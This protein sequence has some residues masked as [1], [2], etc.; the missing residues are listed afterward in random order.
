MKIIPVPCLRDNYAYLVVRNGRAAVVDPSEADPVLLAIEKEGVE[1]VEIWL[2]H[3]H[4]DHVGGIE[5]L[6]D[7]C[8]I[9]AVR[10]STYDQKHGRIP[11][12]TVALSDSDTFEFG[13]SAVDIIEIPGHTLGAIAYVTEGNLFSGDTLFIAGCGRVF[14]GTMEMMS[15]SLAK[16]RDLPPTTQVWCGHEYTVNNLRFAKTV[17]PDNPDI[18]RALEEAIAA[19]AGGKYTVPGRMDRE[20]DTN[21]FLR[22][23][24]PGIARGRDPV[25]SFTTIRGAK[26]NF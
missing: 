12:Q 10:G 5:G 6:F 14:E 21:P 4:W 13:G 15:Q 24:D 20:L 7:E 25:V 17:E 26:D 22:F 3:H 23:D 11:H 19:R 1:L 8:R 9:E 16:L 18:D 2:T